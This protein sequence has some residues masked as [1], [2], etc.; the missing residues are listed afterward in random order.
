MKPI[1][2]QV[3]ATSADGPLGRPRGWT[4]LADP[5]RAD[6]LIFTGAES[7]RDVLPTLTMDRVPWSKVTNGEWDSPFQNDGGWTA[8]AAEPYRRPDARGWSTWR[9]GLRAQRSIIERSWIFGAPQGLCVI[10][11]LCSPR[12]I[13][14]FEPLFDAA[15][16]D[17]QGIERSR[18]RP[19][20]SPPHPGPGPLPGVTEISADDYAWLLDAAGSTGPGPQADP[21]RAARL[22]AFD[23]LEPDGRIG[24]VARQLMRNIVLSRDRVLVRLEMDRS[25]RVL[26]DL[27]LTGPTATAV[28]S[29]ASHRWVGAFHRTRA[30]ELISRFAGIGPAVNTDV[31][32]T[33]VDVARLTARLSDPQTA[34]P[35]TAPPG[36]RTVW[37][38]RLYRWIITV[39]D[40]DSTVLSEQYLGS[41]THGQ[42]R[43]GA[44]DHASGHPGLLLE[45]VPSSELYL[46]LLTILP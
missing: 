25:R 42:Y 39:Q 38:D 9:L 23:A 27:A 7:L 21:E 12:S 44:A 26:L 37:S 20:I 32:D 16:V 8:L 2:L 14:H 46:H 29:T 18:S 45:A 22:N 24:P 15:V 5:S 10:R 35:N 36:L 13:R 31:G 40:G 30:A 1:E 41:V 6:T 43:L 19:S 34:V 28:V 3:P 33:R 11:G 4:R 17:A